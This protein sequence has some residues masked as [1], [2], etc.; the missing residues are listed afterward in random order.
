MVL[1]PEG[2]TVIPFLFTRIKPSLA[3]CFLWLAL[4]SIVLSCAS[5]RAVDRDSTSDVVA[6]VEGAAI[7]ADQLKAKLARSGSA[8]GNADEVSERKRLMLD[9]L[10]NAE[11][12]HRAAKKAGFEEKPEIREALRNFIVSRY[13][14]ETLA[15]LLSKIT[16]SDEEINSYYQGRQ[17]EFTVPPMRR[18][19]LIEVPVPV[20][21]TEEK[22]AELLARA[23]KAR[24]EALGLDPDTASFGQVAVT[25]SDD[26]A[27]RYRGGDMGWLSRGRP[28]RWDAKV[29]E[30]LFSLA[31]TGVISPIITTAH[32]HYLVKLVEMKESYIRPLA[33]VKERIRYQLLNKKREAATAAFFEGLKQSVS[34]T[35]NEELLK[36]LETSNPAPGPPALPGR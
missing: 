15:P 35:I 7:T 32:G 14:E 36:T 8:P 31:H 3:A 25:Y 33:E 13:R 18:G 9:E 29:E 26:Q 27:T 2:M 5:T 16:I 6:R 30:A 17:S 12:L 20:R 23:E 24:A 4:A 28:G 19:A 1:Q 22:K 21:A 34:V 10:V 11:L